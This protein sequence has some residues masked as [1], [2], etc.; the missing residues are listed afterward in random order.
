MRGPVD[1]FFQ[2][3][4]ADHVGVVNQNRPA[5]DKDKQTHVDEAVQGEDVDEDVVG[6]RLRVAIERVERVRG[7]RSRYEP[8]VMRLVDVLVQSRVVLEPVDPVDAR[9]G[10]D[11]EEGHAEDGVC[12]PIVADVV[13][14]ERVTPDLAQEPGQSEQIERCKCIQRTFDLESD[15]VLEETRV[16]LHVVVEKEVVRQASKC[17]VEDKDTDKGNGIKRDALSVEE[18]EILDHEKRGSSVRN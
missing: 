14:K 5:V 6:Q 13:V 10:E 12:Q 11:E 4:V 1:H 15:L 17:E 2:W 3:A 9:V 7:K 16:L 8:L 18:R